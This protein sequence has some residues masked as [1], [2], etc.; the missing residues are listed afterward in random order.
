MTGGYTN[1]S[2][3]GTL[4]GNSATVT[5]ANKA[6]NTG[7]V[8]TLR[9]ASR[10]RSDKATLSMRIESVSMKAKSMLEPGYAEANNGN[11]ADLDTNNFYGYRGVVRGFKT[12]TLEV[13]TALKTMG[14]CPR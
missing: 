13:G 4:L 3:N 5:V 14:A 12:K 8:F 9:N 11:T 7:Y 1:S 6:D 10:A 2:T